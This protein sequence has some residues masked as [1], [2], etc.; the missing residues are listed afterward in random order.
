[1][2]TEGLSPAR[3]LK[4]VVSHTLVF[5]LLFSLGV[6]SWSLLTRC[7]HEEHMVSPFSAYQIDYRMHLI[8]QG[9][10]QQFSKTNLSKL[11]VK[12]G[13]V[14]NAENPKEYSANAMTV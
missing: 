3:A 8:P 14:P 7:A 11:C 13:L 9:Q 12:P 4:A 2:D 10:Y 5:A 6:T 1:M